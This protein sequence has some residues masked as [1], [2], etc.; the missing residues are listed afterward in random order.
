MSFLRGATSAFR[1]SWKKFA[2]RNPRLSWTLSSLVWLP[3]GIV[4]TQNFYTLMVVTGRS[5][6]VVP[7][8]IHWRD[9]VL[10]DRFSVRVRQKYERGDIVALKS[11]NDS[12][13][14]VKRIVALPG[15]T[16]KTLPP[17][18]DPEV[19][20]PP[21][22][23]WVEGDEPYHSEDSNR[24]GPVPLGLLDSKLSFIVWPV[25]RI[26]PILKP[27][28]PGPKAKRGPAW[29]R[30]MDEVDRQRRREA[31]VVVASSDINE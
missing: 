31:R 19:H 23:V 22:H 15:D 16:V 25:E 14:I 1:Q 29:R 27:S 24:F 30:E 20:I 17:Y 2:D 12:L 28:P 9:M 6:Q 4:F 11:P 5:M 10:F 18:P 26:G 3:M 21:G 13:L 8:S 7:I